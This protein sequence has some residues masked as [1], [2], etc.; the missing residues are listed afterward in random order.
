MNGKV[1]IVALNKEPGDTKWTFDLSDFGKLD[2]NAKITVIRTSGTL[3]DGENLA[4]VT[5]KCE[6]KIGDDGTGFEAEI[7]GYSVT[8][9]VVEMK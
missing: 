3:K 6:V 9:F 4:D 1:V 2:K 7:K 5:G 8:T